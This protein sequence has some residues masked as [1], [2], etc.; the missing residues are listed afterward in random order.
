MVMSRKSGAMFEV[1]GG[2]IRMLAFED[3]GRIRNGSKPMEVAFLVPLKP[4]RWFAVRVP[5]L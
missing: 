2:W 3:S 4:A 5:H 1:G